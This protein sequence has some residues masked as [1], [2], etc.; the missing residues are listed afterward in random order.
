MKQYI[1]PLCLV[2]AACSGS[3]DHLIIEN[4]K[5]GLVCPDPTSQDSHSKKHPPKICFENDTL[6][7]TGQGQCVFDNKTYPCTWYGYEFD[8]RNAKPNQK[9]NCIARSN[10]P[11][12]HG[13]PDKIEPNKIE[14]VNSNGYEFELELDHN[15]T[16]FF[17]PSYSTF[18]YKPARENIIKLTTEC[19]SD[20]KRLFKFSKELIF[21]V[22][23]D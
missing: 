4:F 3:K 16:H 21:P 22:K 13:N 12:T 8:Y 10:L 18:E 11:I 19:H 5:S 7:I 9:L 1:Y 14:D 17:N 6:L 23:E 2:L 15:K 20:S